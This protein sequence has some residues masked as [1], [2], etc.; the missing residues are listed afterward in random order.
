MRIASAGDVGLRLAR[1]RTESRM[2]PLI[3]MSDIITGQ[4]YAIHLT[5]DDVVRLFEDLQIA[6]NADARH[7]TE[8]WRALSESNDS[9]RDPLQDSGA[10]MHCAATGLAS[11]GRLE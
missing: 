10:E 3:L 5:I 6:F 2:V 9:A 8:W 4:P 1:H 11:L 7:V